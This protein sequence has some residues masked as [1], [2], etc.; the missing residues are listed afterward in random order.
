MGQFSIALRDILKDLINS[1]VGAITKWYKLQPNPEKKITQ[2]DG[3]LN[4]TLTL[5]KPSIMQYATDHF[6]DMIQHLEEDH[7]SEKK[8][9]E[10]IELDKLPPGERHRLEVIYEFYQT[11]VRYVK[12]LKLLYS[13]LKSPLIQQQTISVEEANQIFLNIEDICHINEPFANELT[14]RK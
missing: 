6:P 1:P 4:L 12:D 8:L 5:P 2:I 10:K 3:E 9:S 13:S 7:S 11:E 14:V